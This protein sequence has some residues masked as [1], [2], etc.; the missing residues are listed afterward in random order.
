MDIALREGNR[1]AFG[2]KSLFDG[3]GHVP[4]DRPVIRRFDLGPTDKID[5]GIGQF[6]HFHDRFGVFED[7]FMRGNDIFENA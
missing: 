1:H 2:V 3:A 6:M 7:P 5:R 4:I